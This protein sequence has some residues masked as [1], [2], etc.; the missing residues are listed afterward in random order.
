MAHNLK[1][2][3]EDI[4]NIDDVDKPVENA[5]IHDVITSLSPLKKGRNANFFDGTIA[6]DTSKIKNKNRWV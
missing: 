1:R 3:H 4:D 2:K 6:D 5:T